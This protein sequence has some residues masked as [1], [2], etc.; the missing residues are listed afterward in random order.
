VSDD[1]WERSELA[2]AVMAELGFSDERQLQGLFTDRLTAALR[3]D[4]HEVLAWDE[5]M[6]ADVD[7]D[8]V[9]CAW[10]TPCAATRG[11]VGTRRR[12]GADAVPLL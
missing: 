4:G 10:R 9:I 3:R 1:E 12:H 2:H 7:Q 8:V 5:V 11:R 6:D